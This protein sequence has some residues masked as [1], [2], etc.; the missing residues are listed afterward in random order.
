[1]AI[2]FPDSPTTGDLFEVAGLSYQWD[3]TVW[4]SVS[5]V[6]YDTQTAINQA[7]NDLVNSAPTTLDTLNELAAALG[8]DQNFAATVTT[9]IGDLETSV[10][11]KSDSGHTHTSQELNWNV[12]STFADLPDANTKHGMVAHV[13][14]EGALYYAH[15]GAWVLIA[16]DAD[17]A[18]LSGA[19]FTGDVTISGSFAA[20]T[21]TE[22]SSKRFKKNIEPISNGLSSILQLQGV[23]FDRVDTEQKEAGLIAE[24]VLEVAPELVTYGAENEIHGVNYT[25]VVAYLIES[26]K[27]LKAEIEELKNKEA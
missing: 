10:A 8:D 24:D 14:T 5:T 20:T 21:V 2:N 19:N 13:H 12:Y 4:K 15:A 18:D 9:S 26:I 25:R 17:K 23:T 16:K 1:M 22:T 3:G 7:I 27:D 6:Q 11:G